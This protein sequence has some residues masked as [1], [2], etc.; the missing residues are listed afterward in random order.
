MGLRQ[1]PTSSNGVPAAP[2][3]RSQS[4]NGLEKGTGR[5]D[6][7]IEAI[8]KSPRVYQEKGGSESGKEGW[9]GPQSPCPMF[10]P[11]NGFFWKKMAIF[12]ENDHFLTFF[13]RKTE[14]FEEIPG[15]SILFPYISTKKP[16]F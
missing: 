12:S 15:F 4:K 2:Y 5:S 8:A 11:R 10:G 3:Q 13:H 6:C 9:G 14:Y 7:E 16:H 1:R